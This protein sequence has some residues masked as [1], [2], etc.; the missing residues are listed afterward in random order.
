MSDDRFIRV[1]L[2]VVSD[3][4]NSYGI[5][6]PNNPSVMTP[7]EL[8]PLSKYILFTERIVKI[9]VVARIPTPTKATTE[10]TEYLKLDEDIILN[11]IFEIKLLFCDIS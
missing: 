3:K 5:V 2:K 8:P 4:A 6:L 10:H 11:F 1:L 7:M 9:H